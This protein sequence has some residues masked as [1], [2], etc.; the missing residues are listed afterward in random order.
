MLFIFTKV[1]YLDRKF[2]QG[3]EMFYPFELIRKHF[4]LRKSTKAYKAYLRSINK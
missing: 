1:Q 4:I 2:K 3:D